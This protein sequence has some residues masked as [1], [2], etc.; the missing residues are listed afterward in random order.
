MLAMLRDLGLEKYIEKDANPPEAADKANLTHKEKEVE[1]RWKED[2][3]KAHMH[4]E[5][6]I[7]DS[8]MIHISGTDSMRGMWEQLTTVKESKGRLRVLATW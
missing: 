2:D 5:L 6:S 1:K 7:G 4:T 3:A 8:E